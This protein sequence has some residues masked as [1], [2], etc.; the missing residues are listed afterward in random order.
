MF[1]FFLSLCYH[2]LSL[3]IIFASS[4]AK[5]FQKMEKCNFPRVFFH[6]FIIFLLFSSFLL[7]VVK[8]FPENGK[9][10]C[11]SRLFHFLSCLIIFYVF[12]NHF[13]IML[14][15]FFIIVAS[16]GAKIFQKWKSA[17]FLEFC[18]HFFDS[19]S[20]NSTFVARCNLAGWL[21]KLL[22]AIHA[23]FDA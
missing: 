2:F 23:S 13:L 18:F 14:L 15:S 10:Q 16:S 12:L 19:K 6:F 20:R 9:L 11:S 3:F 21:M 5:I 4:G 7:P 8:N 22:T 1:M 17:S